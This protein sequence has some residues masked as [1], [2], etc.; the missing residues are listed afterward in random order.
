MGQLLDRDDLGVAVEAADERV[1]DGRA[2]RAGEADERV[3]VEVALAAEEDDEMVEPRPP[4]LG[5]HFG[6]ATTVEV[7]GEVDT[8]DDRTERAGDRRDRDVPVLADHEVA[9]RARR[10]DCGAAHLHLLISTTW[11]ARGRWRLT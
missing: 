1:L 2:D 4:D 8:A 11:A 6:T 5:G 9:H 7:T 3:V 10:G